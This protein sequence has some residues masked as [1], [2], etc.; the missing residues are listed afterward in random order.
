MNNCTIR[1]IGGLG[2]QINCYAFGRAIAIKNNARLKLDIK[3]GYWNDP[4]GREYLLNM[5]PGLKGEILKIPESIIGRFSFQVLIKIGQHISLLFPLKWRIVVQEK[6]PFCYKREVHKAEFYFSTYFIGYWASY[7]YY[8]GIEDQLR[9]ELKPQKPDHPTALDLL[10]TIEAGRSCSIHFRTYEEER[11]ITHS[12]LYE[13]YKKAVETIIAKHPEITFYVFSD[14]P[15]TA[16]ERL[17]YLK[18]KTVYIDIPEARGNI[19][20][21]IDFY[22]MYACSDAIIGDS[23]FSWWAAWLSDSADKNIIAPVGLSPWGKDW[24]PE[25]WTSINCIP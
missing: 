21:L 7:L 10:R 17:S 13:Y 24:V 16:R 6:A 8:S 15:K 5:F 2:N 1:I 4:F 22:L 14:N 18:I 25:N 23:T 9:N 11:G 3:S 20:S 12:S 19:Q